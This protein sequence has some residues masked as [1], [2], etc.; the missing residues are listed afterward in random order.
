[1]HAKVHFSIYRR[2][3]PEW[4]S[5]IIN[6]E[7]RAKEVN[8]FRKGVNYSRTLVNLFRKGDNFF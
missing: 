7:N 2:K 5:E 8:Y 4:N 6:K 1:M 3:V